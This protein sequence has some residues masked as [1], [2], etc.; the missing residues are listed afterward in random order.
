MKQT[1]TRLIISAIFLS[2][3]TGGLWADSPITSTNFY[4]AY[5][6]VALVK[7]ARA[8]KILSPRMAK[9]LSNPEAPLDQKAALINALSWRFKGKSN[10]DIYKYFLARKYKTRAAVLNLADLNTG[11]IFSLGYL[12][13]MDNYF[14]PDRA[15][16]LLE[17][18]RKRDNKSFTIAMI[19]AITRAQAAMKNDW[20][21]VWRLTEAVLNDKSL[22]KDLRESAVQIIVDYMKLYQSSCKK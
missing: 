4:K 11:E 14:K 22:N 8:Q 21:E 3:M 2:F 6:D 13:V 18:A 16:P 15:I 20:C 7:E 12:S 17:E 1:Y 9:F 10:S 19:L 5:Q